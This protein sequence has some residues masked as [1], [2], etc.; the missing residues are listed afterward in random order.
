ML[1]SPAF[2][3]APFPLSL[4]PRS[5]KSL[6]TKKTLAVAARKNR[7]LPN[8]IRQRTGNTIRYNAMRRNWRRTKVR[9]PIRPPARSPRAR[10]RLRRA[11][12]PARAEDGALTDAP[13]PPTTPPHPSPT[14]L[15][16]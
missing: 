10:R 9:P 3:P 5:Q 1:T 12:P 4:P 11:P 6:R 16:I 2:G 14:Q 15:G 13:P 8:W 7:L